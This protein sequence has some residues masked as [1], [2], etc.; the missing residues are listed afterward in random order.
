MKVK[1]FEERRRSRLIVFCA[2]L[3]VV[4]FPTLCVSCASSS[5]TT[6]S[7]Q[8]RASS[9]A[10]AAAKERGPRQD[11][12]VR[13]SPVK[14]WP[15]DRD[16]GGHIVDDRQQDNGFWA[17]AG[18]LAEA[19]QEARLKEEEE[20]SLQA[21]RERLA[22]RT[23]TA[24]LVITDAPAGSRI[25]I[26]SRPPVSRGLEL[27][28]SAIKVGGED[29]PH[30]PKHGGIAVEAGKRHVRVEA[31]GFAPFETL[32]DC[33]DGNT[34]IVHWTA[35]A[36]SFKILS[37]VLS[38]NTWRRTFPASSRH[39]GFSFVIK[40]VAPG[41]LAMEIFDAN[42]QRVLRMTKTAR[43]QDELLFWD[44]TGN[45]GKP[46]PAGRY[47]ARL[48]GFEEP[49]AMTILPAIIDSSPS[50]SPSALSGFW[51]APD[52]G[53][54]KGAH[55]ELGGLA[56]AYMEQG[57]S[58]EV[59]MD[60][61]MRVPLGQK[62]NGE[63]MWTLRAVLGQSAAGENL[64][65]YGSAFAIKYR[66][67]PG[68]GEGFRAA[69]F[70]RASVDR[71]AD[72]ALSSWPP[73]TDPFSSWS[74]GGAGAVVEYRTRLL[75]ACLSLEYAMSD[76]YPELMLEVGPIA[77]PYYWWTYLRTG[78][79]VGIPFGTRN[80]LDLSLSM[81][82]RSR[83]GSFVWPFAGPALVAAECRFL[84]ADSALSP[85]L[86]VTGSFEDLHNWYYAAGGGL[87]FRF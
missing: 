56:T 79:S 43:Q 85:S 60:W 75:R 59:L 83:Q 67:F 46:V 72:V 23:R 81:A 68:Q 35:P 66:I 73:P 80:A 51:H 18:A 22:L 32:V 70:A 57:G 41:P 10:K 37:C 42:D 25:Y 40:T 77:S 6:R 45:D 21:A 86:L 61:S 50:A 63:F 84:T 19:A 38:Q 15:S 82:L 64:G 28:G 11:P 62:E 12:D 17:L 65:T 69:L 7:S 34:S 9:K 58:S 49:F 31:F 36:L 54:L 71:W 74:S 55:V 39:S 4:F 26:D 16:S 78:L 53:T 8:D 1:S 20:K 30:V 24:T 44:G 52:A 3:A 2:F 76:L 47:S 13:P 29:S 48:D 14:P 33:T 27:Q 87:V 5:G